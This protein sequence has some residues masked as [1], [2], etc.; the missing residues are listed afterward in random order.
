MYMYIK[1]F[2]GYTVH[3]QLSEQAE[4]NLKMGCSDMLKT[5][6]IMNDLLSEFIAKITIKMVK[7][8]RL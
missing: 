8:C 1:S 4:L 5:G 3:P 6:I 2:H 7:L